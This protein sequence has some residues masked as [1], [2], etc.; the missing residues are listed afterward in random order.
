M[1]LPH[2]TIEYR[3][4]ETYALESISLPLLL[5]FGV[6][7]ALMFL[8][9]LNDVIHVFPAH[10]TPALVFL[11]LFFAVTTITLFCYSFFLKTAR[12]LFSTPK[13]RWRNRLFGACLLE[14]ALLLMLVPGSEAMQIGFMVLAGILA[15]VGSAVLTMSFGVS[16]SVCDLPAVVISIA[17]AMPLGALIL[18]LIVLLH[19]VVPVVALILCLTFP[20]L[21]LLGLN[22]SSTKLIDNLEFIALTMPV[23]TRELAIRLIAP[24]L[25]F[26]FMIGLTRLRLAQSFLAIPSL[27]DATAPLILGGLF[28]GMSLLVAMF[29]QRKAH[30]FAFRTLIPLAALLLGVSTIWGINQP[31]IPVFC[32]FAGYLIFMGCMWILCSDI[33]QRFRI[34]A[35]SAF[36]FGYGAL[37]LGACIAVAL[38]SPI[39][40]FSA[41]ISNDAYFFAAAL[42]C[43][44]LGLSVLP[45][46]SE[47]LRTLK[48]GRT[49]PAFSEDVL[50][51]ETPLVNVGEP[52]LIAAES[53]C[54][55]ETCENAK[56]AEGAGVNLLVCDEQQPAEA[57]GAGA[58]V[59]V[60][61][62]EAVGA[63]VDNA[64][65]GGKHGGEY[66]DGYGDEHARG[67]TVA[68]HTGGHAPDPLPTY[69]SEHRLEHPAEH[70][71]EHRLEHR[72]EPAPEVRPAATPD[73]ALE[74]MP[75]FPPDEASKPAAAGR[76]KRKCAMVANTFLLSRK[77]TEV[78]YLLA[79]GRNSATI[80]ESLYISAGTANTHMRHIYRKLDVH[81]QGELIDLVES[82]N[83]GPDVE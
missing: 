7:W 23:N 14:A 36:G 55:V 2:I 58:G 70:Q 49:C 46:N 67:C 38:A 65:H 47:L 63:H 79:R 71:S 25:L 6:H 64:G 8:L 74:H 4:E 75:D 3:E 20:F 80:Q 13:K 22:V 24:S 54:Q 32:E 43:I 28:M 76:F 30:N 57:D 12:D 1:R 66:V 82:M 9:A 21:E 72:S 48:R 37:L 26:G 34:S 35:F 81:S 56:G 18:A 41:L 51:E 33:S 73:P 52:P 16:S 61:A 19:S 10:G 83:P 78:L 60:E 50:L 59:G 53:A 5:G 29:T 40:P 68:G 62:A 69:Q 39:S 17:A 11:I 15:G 44:T 77:E 27:L 31:T 42:V 45:H